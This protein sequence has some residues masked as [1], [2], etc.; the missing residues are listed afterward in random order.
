[1]DNFSISLSI[2]WGQI[3]TPYHNM[4]YLGFFDSYYCSYHFQTFYNF[5][6]ELQFG[7]WRNFPFLYHCF[8]VKFELSSQYGLY[9]FL[10]FLLLFLPFQNRLQFWYELQFGLWI[11]F[12]SLLSLWGRITT[13]FIIKIWAAIW[14]M[15][16]FSFYL[17]LLWGQI[18]TPYH[19]GLFRFLWFLL[20]FLPFPN[21]LQFRYGPQFEPL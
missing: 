17:S 1:M 4:G 13:H 12:Q 15:E 6:L 18:W 9:R 21:S 20:L 14:A 8:M 5:R 16:N 7:L 19:K 3:W 11:I 2:L 10:W